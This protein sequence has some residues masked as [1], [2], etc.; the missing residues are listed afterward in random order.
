VGP[1]IFVEHI[2]PCEVE[3]AAI[4]LVNRQEPAKKLRIKEL[5]FSRNLNSRI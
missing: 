2:T 1:H 5:Y 4:V 3:D